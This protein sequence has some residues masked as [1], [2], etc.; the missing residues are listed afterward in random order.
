MLKRV[1]W[2][3]PTRLLVLEYAG[4]LT[5]QMMESGV[6][7]AN[8]L[9]ATEGVLPVHSIFDMSGKAGLSA[10][11][12]NLKHLRNMFAAIGPGANHDA[13]T[14]TIDPK[15]QGVLPSMAT[16]TA[17]LARRRLQV[18]GSM[19]EALAFLYQQDSSLAQMERQTI[20][21]ARFQL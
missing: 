14:V 5:P 15:P 7:Q 17:Q 2:K 20:E 18:T 4:V 10:D 13:W 9:L 16:M 1:Y 8:A 12:Y 11:F 6:H 21:I 3:I 19:A